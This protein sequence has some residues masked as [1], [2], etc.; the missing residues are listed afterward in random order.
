MIRQLRLTGGAPAACV[1]SA[2]LA[3]LPG[4]A[5]MAR[6]PA[7]AVPPPGATFM[8][9]R[10]AEKAQDDP[11]DPGLLPA[12]EARARRLAE[13][14]ANA[15]LRAVYAT[16]FRRTRLTAAPTADAHGLSIWIHDPAEPPAITA[17]RLRDTHRDGV[18]LV[19]GHSNTL[20]PLAAA[21]CGCD[22]APM[23]ESE[24]GRYYRLRSPG[25]GPARLEVLAW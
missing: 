16:P 22:V 13:M 10:H 12:G 4:C 19:V 15:P 3:L 18:V 21:L 8:L 9:V 14:L 23:P 17:A 11:R 1:L 2:L 25:A 6:G 24:Y 7:A 5:S 20:P